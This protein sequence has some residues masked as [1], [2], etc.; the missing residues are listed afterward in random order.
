MLIVIPVAFVVVC[1]C[2][3]VLLVQVNAIGVILSWSW[4]TPDDPE[5]LRG[6]Y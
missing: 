4:V 2:A 5:L 1:H 6:D 3:W